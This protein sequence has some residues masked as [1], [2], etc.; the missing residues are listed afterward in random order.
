[1]IAVTA[2]QGAM[3]RR[4]VRTVLPHANRNCLAIRVDGMR[5]RPDRSG[6][7]DEIDLSCL[8]DEQATSVIAIVTST[9]G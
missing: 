1:M 5:Q 7:D 8:R 6:D 3:R 2:R 9:T 4:A